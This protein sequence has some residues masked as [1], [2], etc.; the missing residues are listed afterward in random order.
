MCV[1]DMQ[2][3]AHFSLVWLAFV[4]PLGAL[5]CCIA[6]LNTFVIPFASAF[7]WQR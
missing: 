3:P 2:F 5:K 6:L 4:L 7:A 1:Y